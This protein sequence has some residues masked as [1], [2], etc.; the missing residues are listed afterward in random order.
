MNATHA[1]HAEYEFPDVKPV[2]LPEWL[3]SLPENEEIVRIE[4]D[5]HIFLHAR[6]ANQVYA[7]DDYSFD[8]IPEL[9]PV[10]SR[11]EH[12][13]GLSY[14]QYL[15]VPRSAIQN[16][17]RRWQD[18]LAHL[19]EEMDATLDWRPKESRYYCFL[20]DSKGRYARDPLAEYR[21]GDGPP[22]KEDKEK[23]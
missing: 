20:K 11:M 6:K 1:G 21:H 13:W 15:T 2:S 16:M 9:Q 4:E 23:A 8:N 7:A 17:P 10:S 3:A 22:R 5:G 14:A 18:Q 12:F 19:M